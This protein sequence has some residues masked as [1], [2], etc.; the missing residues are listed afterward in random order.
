MFCDI[1][2]IKAFRTRQNLQQFVMKGNNVSFLP[3]IA[4]YCLVS[5]WAL[6]GHDGKS[7]S[8]SI[9]QISSPSI[10]V[11]KRLSRAVFLPILEAIYS[12][13]LNSDIQYL[14]MTKE[15]L[16]SVL[17]K[18][19]NSLPILKVTIA[20]DRRVQFATL[21]YICNFI[22]RH[23]F[24][25]KGLLLAIFSFLYE[26]LIVHPSVFNS[27]VMQVPELSKT[28]VEFQIS[29]QFDPDNIDYDVLEGKSAALIEI[30]SLLLTIMPGAFPT[31]A[32]TDALQKRNISKK[33]TTDPPKTE[34][35]TQPEKT[36][37]ESK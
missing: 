21:N 26:K 11:S 4:I 3:Y 15:Q 22:S 34:E 27:W 36:Q 6:D 31:H 23:N 30:N 5:G 7:A 17:T 33:Q 1:W 37:Q 2:F 18:L 13:P 20:I 16:K 25:P 32:R 10:F 29:R 35:K 14:E 24:E 12:Q 19:E 9:S 8:M 28:F